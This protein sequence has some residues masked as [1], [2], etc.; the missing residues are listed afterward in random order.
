MR[1]SAR[2]GS[3]L[4]ATTSGRN[5]TFGS[6]ASAVKIPISFARRSAAGRDQANFAMNRSPMTALDDHHSG[7]ALAAGSGHGTRDRAS[8]QLRCHGSLRLAERLGGALSQ[9]FHT[10]EP[11]TS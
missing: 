4:L 10:R 1:F 7:S 2:A 6:R 11:A 9:P 5:G 8:A 3:V